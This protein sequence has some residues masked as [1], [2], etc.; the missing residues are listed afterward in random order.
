MEIWVRN[1]L[2]CLCYT[3]GFSSNLCKVIQMNQ[4]DAT[5]IYW[6]IRSFKHVSDNILLIIR[7]VRLR[8]FTACGILLLWWAGR[9]WAAAW[10]CQYISTSMPTLWLSQSDKLYITSL[11]RFVIVSLRRKLSRSSTIKPMPCLR[12]FTLKGNISEP[13]FLKVLDLLA[14]AIRK[15]TLFP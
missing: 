5:M 10:H 12:Y 8:F 9:R 4:L 2:S 6:S 14:S 1:C 15:Y 13:N 3:Y 7:S 11:L